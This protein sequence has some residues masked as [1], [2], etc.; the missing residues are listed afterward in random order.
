LYV[1]PRQNRVVTGH[2]LYD[3]LDAQRGDLRTRCDHSD[4]LC[5]NP[6]PATNAATRLAAGTLCSGSP[7]PTANEEPKYAYNDGDGSTCYD[8]EYPLQI[9]GFDPNFHFV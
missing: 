4:I 8:A 9:H 7:A 2:S 3:A 1:R 6:V 5:S